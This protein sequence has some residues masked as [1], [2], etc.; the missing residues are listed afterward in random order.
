MNK[1][2]SGFQKKKK[3]P[4]DTQIRKVR[5]QIRGFK[6]KLF[7]LYTLPVFIAALAQAVIKEYTKIKVRQAASSI[8]ADISKV[9]EESPDAHLNQ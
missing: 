4:F 7:L 5:K 9:S 1:L 6:I 8:Q 3:G 2:L